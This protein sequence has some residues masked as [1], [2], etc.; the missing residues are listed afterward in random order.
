MRLRKGGFDLLEQLERRYEGS[1]GKGIRRVE[2]LDSLCRRSEGKT[3]LKGEGGSSESEK[4]GRVV[5]VESG[6]FTDRLYMI[7][8][9]HDYLVNP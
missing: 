9:T 7:F 4:G 8:C 3:Y 5:N 1:S 6:I 2:S